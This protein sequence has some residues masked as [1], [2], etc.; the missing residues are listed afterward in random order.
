[1][2]VSSQNLGRAKST[3]HFFELLPEFSGQDSVAWTEGALHQD[4]ID[5]TAVLEADGPECPYQVEAAGA[6]QG[7]RPGIPGITDHRDHLALS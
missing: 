4:A 5:P 7:D 6:V 1:M 3:A 2:G